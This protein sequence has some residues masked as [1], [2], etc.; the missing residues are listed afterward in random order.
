MPCE[1]DVVGSVIVIWVDVV[2][3]IGH[4]VDLESI[5][6]MYLFS[7]LFLLV[8]L[9]V[10][11]FRSHGSQ[12]PSCVEDTRTIVLGLERRRRLSGVTQTWCAPYFP[13]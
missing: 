8:V 5:I 10:T 1:G 2:G 6:L 7:F 9:V 11:D 12:P 4:T 13:L 3:G